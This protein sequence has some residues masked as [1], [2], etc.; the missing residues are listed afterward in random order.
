MV[1]FT[2]ISRKPKNSAARATLSVE[3]IVTTGD[4]VKLRELCLDAFKYVDH[5]ELNIESIGTY[6]YA[7]NIFVC[8]LRRTAPFLS[9]SLS[10][11]GEQEKHLICVYESALEFE[12]NRC[13]F[14]CGGT[15]CF[16]EN[17]ITSTRLTEQEPDP[18]SGRPDNG[19]GFDFSLYQYHPSFAHKGETH[20][21]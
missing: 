2:V 16:W 20:D 14:S 12:T 5:L 4:L 6:D 15:Y 21:T 7:F 10:V 8:L 18:K 9:K 19:P 3:G 1:A 13:S 17:L 11:L